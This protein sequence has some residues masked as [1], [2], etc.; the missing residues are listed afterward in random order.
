MWA[1]NRAQWLAGWYLS[2]YGPTPEELVTPPT[3]TELSYAL[4]RELEHLERHVID[5]PHDAYE[6]RCAIFNGSRIL[7]ALET[8]DTALSKRAGGLWALAHL[9]KEWHEVIRIANR[10]YDRDAT[11]EEVERLV[12]AMAPFVAMV[13]T[14]VPQLE[15]RT[16]G[17]LP[18]W[19]V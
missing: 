10:T 3:W 19:S 13:R 11:A 8:R 4:G 12:T 16:P 17:A 14:Q 5:G 15:D 1:V 9:S 2:L 7:H 18:R 6:G